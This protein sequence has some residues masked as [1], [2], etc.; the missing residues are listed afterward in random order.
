MGGVVGIAVGLVCTIPPAVFFVDCVGIDAC[1][2]SVLPYA[3]RLIVQSIKIR[4]AKPHPKPIF[5]V[6]FLE[7]NHRPNDLF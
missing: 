2:G 6:R 1:L 5:V 4:K 7:A 3:A